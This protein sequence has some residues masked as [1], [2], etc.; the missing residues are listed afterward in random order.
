M[1]ALH[2]Q[3]E[4]GSGE[5]LV[6]C[7]QQDVV[8]L[9]PVRPSVSPRRQLSPGGGG[10]LELRCVGER[11]GR[12]IN[13]AIQSDERQRD[14]H[15]AA[16]ETAAATEHRHVGNDTEQRLGRSEEE[17]YVKNRKYNTCTSHALPP[18]FLPQT[19]PVANWLQLLVQTPH[20]VKQTCCC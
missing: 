1:L 19:D 7:L 13:D 15:D 6:D 9:V 12:A 2:E 10:R 8:P 11:E 17:T 16:Q 18:A 4:V 5:L 3:V 14:A 20:C